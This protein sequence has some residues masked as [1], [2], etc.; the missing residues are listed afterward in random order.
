[1][2]RPYECKYRDCDK[3]FTTRFSLRRHI[4]THAPAKQ[5]ICVICYKKF[6]LGQYLKEHTYIHTG[7]KP[8]K[9]PYEGCTKAFRQAGK[10]SLHKKL[11]QNKIF[12][13]QKV[14]RRSSDLK[15]C[16]SSDHEHSLDTSCT[17]QNKISISLCKRQ[18][19]HYDSEGTVDS[20]LLTHTTSSPRN[21]HVTVKLQSISSV[22]N[23]LPAAP[24]TQVKLP[25]LRA[26]LPQLTTQDRIAQLSQ[27]LVYPEMVHTRSLPQ[28]N[29]KVPSLN[30]AMQTSLTSAR[31]RQAMLEVRNAENERINDHFLFFMRLQ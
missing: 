19:P 31:H 2:K 11:H 10:L 14:K 1:M 29:L 18:E 20:G 4:S 7:Q 27:S 25:S 13:V 21:S 12:I 17:T 26:A 22:L 3:K 15:S 24:S 28:P 23:R 16:C 30:D 5:Y 8:F 9:C 6:A